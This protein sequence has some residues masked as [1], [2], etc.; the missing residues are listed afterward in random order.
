VR[1]LVGG[2][3]AH[4]SKVIHLP[5]TKDDPAKRRPDIAV[6]K[7]VGWRWLCACVCVCVCRWV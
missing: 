1:E 6:A 2:D 5:A 4:Q 3:P 7:K